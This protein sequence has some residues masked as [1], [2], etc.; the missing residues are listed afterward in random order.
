MLAAHVGLGITSAQFDY[1]IGNVIVPALTD[2]GVKHGA[3]GAADPNDV[4]SCFA[5]VV[6]DAAFKASIVGH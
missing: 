1:L 4:A 3:G 6:T 2:N 5:P